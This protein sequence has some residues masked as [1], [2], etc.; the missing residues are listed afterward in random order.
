MTY[1]IHPDAEAELLDAAMFYAERASKVIAAAFLDEFERVLD[2][3]VDNQ[4]RG[5][6]SDDGL[7]VYHFDRF[8]YSVI[9]ED[10]E[11]LGPQILAIAHQRREPGYWRDRM[12]Q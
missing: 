11:A 9:Y 2:L 1:A 8:P 12:D 7:R 10:N 4:H 3:I 6:K 5:A